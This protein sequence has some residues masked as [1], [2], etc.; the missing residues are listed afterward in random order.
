M[1]IHRS[2]PSVFGAQSVPAGGNPGPADMG[3]VNLV[4]AH[5]T[6]SGLRHHLIP[7]A[8]A[9]R[10]FFV[11]GPERTE[12][13]MVF[14]NG[15]Y[16]GHSAW[17]RQD[18][19]PGFSAF[20]RVFIDYR[21]IGGSRLRSDEE[22]SFDDVVDDVAA[23]CS[24]AGLQ[25]PTV[26]IGF[27]V[28]GMVALRLLQRHPEISAGLVILNS[29]TRVKQQVQRMIAAAVQLLEAGA[30]LRPLI[31]ML[32]PWNHSGRYLEK[33]RSMEAELLDGCCRYNDRT[34][35]LRLLAALEHK[36]DLVA[37][38]RAVRVPSLVIGSD[39]DE[40]FPLEMQREL[41]ALI[42][43]SVFHAVA[44]CGHSS[45]IERPVEINQRIAEFVNASLRSCEM[46]SRASTPGGTE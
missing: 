22:F 10:S 46:G 27:S 14:L 19:F 12:R 2:Q 38:C 8:G 43:N 36:P 5:G 41:A 31:Q 7:G 1:R 13:S 4:E 30:S 3:A 25:G 28:G 34:G 40:V 11:S 39:A 45:F 20:R 35:F 21:G 26:I 18:R 9:E 6:K 24:A 15:L 32:Y 37:A 33:V 42:E 17:L 29:G 23:T 16:H 44:G